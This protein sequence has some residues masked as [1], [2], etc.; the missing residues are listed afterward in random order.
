MPTARELLEQAD[1]LMRRNRKR[2]RGTS[3]D[4]PTLA[5][6]IDT[7]RD[8]LAPTV[9]LPDAAPA[10]D[11]IALDAPIQ[12]DEPPAPSPTT[13]EPMSLDSLGDVP[14]LTDVVLDWPPQFP[15][16]ESFSEIVEAPAAQSPDAFPRSAEEAL[17]VAAE[18]SAPEVLEREEDA[19]TASAAGDSGE[20]ALHDEAPAP[21]DGAPT[22]SSTPRVP[23]LDDDFIL[24]VPPAEEKAPPPAQSVQPA[25]VVADEPVPS[26]GREWEGVIEEIRMQVL[27][28]LDLFTDTG[29][30]EQLGA[31]LA[32]IVERASAQLIETI[33]RELGELVRGYVAEAIERE[34][35]SWRRQNR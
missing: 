2:G 22:S 11:P 24:E 29:L 33:N 16:S 7:G 13:E 5:A 10:A 3:G 21:H 15:S 32:P 17:A 19:G 4:V 25:P 9:I 14:V 30:R 34:I 6:A 1:A 18:H 12:R 35:E 27:Q 20:V 31:R 28:R 23:F 26:R 8:V